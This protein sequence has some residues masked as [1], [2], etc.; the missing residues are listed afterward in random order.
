MTPSI[1]RRVLGLLTTL[2]LAPSA[3]A[4]QAGTPLSAAYAFVASVDDTRALWVNPGGLAAV[5]E[6]SL[7]GGFVLDR[8]ATGS[9]RLAQW[10]LGFN[11]RG[12]AFGY[13]RDRLPDD[14]FT[15]S[16]DPRST[17]AYRFGFAVPFG[18]GALGGSFSIYSGN[19]T[20]TEF[21]GDVGLRLALGRRL[22]F[23]AV[24]T[25][26]GRPVL[27]DVKAPLSGTVGLAWYAV[28]QVL[29]IA[30]EGRVVEGLGPASTVLETRAGFHFSPGPTTPFSL[31]AAIDLD[32]RPAVRSL[33]VGVTIG[34]ADRAGVTARTVRTGGA[35]TFA[36]L[37]VFGV[38]RRGPARPQP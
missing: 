22:S 35:A 21:G 12:L 24:A 27:G 20:G 29:E 19:A 37:G 25:N 8:F 14:P 1:L 5:P 16:A 3:L 4:A 15:P 13:Q 26:L 36:D 18:S 34:A 23:G 10:S 30:A 33:V 28:P 7:A 6:Y 32:N 2:A 31:L 17:S 38:A 9:F 11:S